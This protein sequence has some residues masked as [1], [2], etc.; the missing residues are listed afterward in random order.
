MSYSL[1]DTQPGSP[2]KDDPVNLKPTINPEDDTPARGGSC[3]LTAVIGGLLLFVAVLIVALSAAAGWTAGQREASTNATVTQQA[4]ISEQLE[5]IPAEIASGNL[6][7]L[8]VRLRWLATQT[9]GV[10]GIADFSMTATALYQSSL[11]TATPEFTPTPEA[12]AQPEETEALVL[13]AETSG[14]YDLAGPFWIRRKRRLRPA[15]GKKP[16]VC[17]T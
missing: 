1:D 14:G 12:T 9:P 15:S 17:W 3:L 5:R 6:A 7:M 16:A 13:P 8:D 10:P 11:P 2:F 4:A